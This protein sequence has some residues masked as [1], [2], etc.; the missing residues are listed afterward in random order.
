M[1]S[2]CQL[3]GDIE[4]LQQQ[5]L[6]V[7][8]QSSQRSLSD[9]SLPISSAVLPASMSRLPMASVLGSHFADQT[10]KASWQV[11]SFTGERLEVSSARSR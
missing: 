4:I 9:T 2:L 6:I 3:N 10:S 11:P 8:S 7:H 1:V 5:T